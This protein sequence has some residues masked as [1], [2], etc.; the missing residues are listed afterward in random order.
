M[1]E[2]AIMRR[3]LVCRI[4]VRLPQTIETSGRMAR[5][6]AIAG[7][8]GAV[9]NSRSAASSTPALMMVAMYAV[10]GRLAPS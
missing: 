7:D 4:A 5:S 10:T 6:P 2:Y 9:P 1:D 8:S 3:K